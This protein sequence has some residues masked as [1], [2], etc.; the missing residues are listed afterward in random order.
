[1]EES[2]KRELESLKKELAGKRDEIQDIAGLVGREIDRQFMPDPGELS[3]RELEA[4]FQ[5]RLPLLRDR[6]DI[7]PNPAALTSHRKILGRPILFLKRKFMTMIRFYTQLITPKQTEFNAASASLIEAIIARSRRNRQALQEIE[8]RIGRLEEV[9]I[10]LVARL[11]DIQ[12]R[13]E[14]RE[15]QTVARR[16]SEK[17]EP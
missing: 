3:E 1:M 14:K 6:I 13:V 4:F 7:N 11:R 2:L 5:E 9:L 15:E 12:E 10:L 16:T 8:E 17:N